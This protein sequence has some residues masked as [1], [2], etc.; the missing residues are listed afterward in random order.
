MANQVDSVTSDTER[1]ATDLSGTAQQTS[2]QISSDP[3]QS[4][5]ASSL[6]PTMTTP[7]TPNTIANDNNSESDNDDRGDND[8]DDNDDSDDNNTDNDNDDSNN[9]RVATQS[10]KKKNKAR[11]PAKVITGR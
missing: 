3:R 1:V 7:V 11:L 9:T 6:A 10:R 8:G 2:V 5:D 4:T